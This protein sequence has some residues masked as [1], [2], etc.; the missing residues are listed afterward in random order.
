MLALGLFYAWFAGNFFGIPC[1]FHKLTG[2]KC[3]GCGVTRMML[4][5]L[6]GDLRG[7]FAHNA[8]ILCLLPA[9]AVLAV[10]GS[11]RYVQT[12]SRTMRPWENA[13]VWCMTGVL[14]L[15]GLGRNL[16]QFL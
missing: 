15:Y 3:P 5:L 2:L 11:I 8:A 9:G 12:G 6:D 4:D 1:L 13:L 16:T 14:L 10:S 7:A